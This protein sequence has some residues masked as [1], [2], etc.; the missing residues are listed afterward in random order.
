MFQQEQK[1]PDL[2]LGHKPLLNN[3]PEL[4][5]NGKPINSNQDEKVPP[6]KLEGQPTDFWGGFKKS[7]TSGEAGNAMDEGARGWLKGAVL[8]LPSSI[9][10][11]LKSGLQVLGH[12]MISPLIPMPEGLDILNMWNTTKQAGMNPDAFGE[13]MGQIGGQPLVTAGLT[14]GISAAIPKVLT[15]T[16][17]GM[18]TVGQ[19]MGKVRTIGGLATVPTRLAGRGIAR[20]GEALKDKFNPVPEELGPHFNTSGLPSNVPS[21]DSFSNP[22]IKGPALLPEPN[23]SGSGMPSSMNNPSGFSMPDMPPEPTAIN[24]AISQ[25]ISGSGY[26]TNVNSPSF[27][28]KMTGESSSTEGL[29]T[30]KEPKLVKHRMD[31]LYK[32]AISGNLTLDEMK[33]IKKLNGDVRKVSNIVSDFQK[34]QGLDTPPEALGSVQTNAISGMPTAAENVLASPVEAPIQKLG[35]SD[36]NPN[37]TITGETAKN[38]PTLETNNIVNE[39]QL[40]DELPPILRDNAKNIDPNNF[41]AKDTLRMQN[42]RFLRNQDPVQIAKDKEVM[43]RWNEIQNN[44][45]LEKNSHSNKGDL[46]DRT[47]STSLPI[48]D[49]DRIQ[50]RIDLIMKNINKKGSAS[51]KTV[52]QIDDLISQLEKLKKGGN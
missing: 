25:S 21:P 12:Q 42:D 10:G 18:S 29:N 39:P 15:T 40:V 47:T 33:E 9:Y 23:M 37:P 30:P 44:L 34:S 2:D 49:V 7:F 8:D 5:I 1:P 4:D 45:R 31:E 36:A 38:P 19:E 20:I 52:G 41:F 16:G 26:P 43:D 27:F 3:P 6:T 13:M 14:K 24:P 32:K 22:N 11:G 17:K 51:L 28:S 50:N 35:Q 48:S 46:F